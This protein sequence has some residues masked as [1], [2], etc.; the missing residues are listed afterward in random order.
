MTFQQTIIANVLAI[1]AQSDAFM[2]DTCNIRRKTGNNVINGENIPI[3]ADGV[4]TR[5]RLVIRSGSESTNIAAQERLVAHAM[6]TGIYRLQLPFETEISVDD[7][8]E[9]TD[10]VTGAVRTFEATFVPPFTEMMG[11]F[12]IAVREVV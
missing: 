7:H 4:A 12:I 1:R 5:C 6:F 10:I 9:F 8:I 3:Y 2:I 11:A